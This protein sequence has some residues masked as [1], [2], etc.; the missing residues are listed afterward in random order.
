[1]YR[2]IRGALLVGEF[3]FI[4][5]H[6]LSPVYADPVQI[7]QI[8][9]NLV[10]NAREAMPT[11]GKLTIETAN[12]DF[13]TDYVRK[14]PVARVGPYVMVAISD[15]GI[16]VDE[17]TKNH[18]FEPFYTTKERGKGTGLGLATVYG[19]VKQSDGFIWVYGEPGQG[20][21]FKIYFP[22]GES[23]AVRSEALD[24]SESSYRGSET[25]LMVED[26]TAVRT[27]ASRILNDRGYKVLDA[28]D[29]MEALH[30]SGEYCSE[31]HMIVTD[32]VMP[33]LS[34]TRLVSRLKSER[35]RIKALYVSGYTDNAVV[36]HGI[37]DSNVAFLQKP[38]TVENLTR[39]VGE[40]LDT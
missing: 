38:F 7:Q 31:I 27:L 16:G 9:M 36:H 25:I 21:T 26:E 11:G 1:M 15:N 3:V 18:M 17:E 28:A 24:K 35:P 10:V 4:P 40:V 37:L 19:I 39:K 22:R 20:T 32:V 34:G 30:L 8:I 13:D 2:T 14:H 23:G 12:V 33:G 5:G 29:G 6:E